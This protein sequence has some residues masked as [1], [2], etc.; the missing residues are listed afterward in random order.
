LTLEHNYPQGSH[1]KAL[2]DVNLLLSTLKSND[3]RI[4]EWVNILGYITP[5]P[6]E[7]QNIII[8]SIT[9]GEPRLSMV[10]AILLWSAGSVRLQEYERSLAKRV[11]DG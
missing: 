5:T 8:G 7:T 9:S 4:G 10:Q 2:V 3:T 11:L 6:P 1:H